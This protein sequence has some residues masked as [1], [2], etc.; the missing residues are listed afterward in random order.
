L[1]FYNKKDEIIEF[2]DEWIPIH[3]KIH[4]N[5]SLMTMFIPNESE[6]FN[7]GLHEDKTNNTTMLVKDLL[8]PGVKFCA[9]YK[10]SALVKS[11]VTTKVVHLRGAPDLTT[12]KED[13]QKALGI[14]KQKESNKKKL[15]TNEKMF[16]EYITSLN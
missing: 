7:E 12:L 11:Q 8:I 6:I 3:I 1:Y 10:D 16:F 14:I 5:D 13:V 9:K 2:I 15:T 4:M